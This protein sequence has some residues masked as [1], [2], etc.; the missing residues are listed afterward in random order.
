MMVTGNARR[1]Q[2]DTG[3]LTAWRNAHSERDRDRD[4]R[5][6]ADQAKAEAC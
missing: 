6:H 5:H 3:G 4:W 1:M 2:M